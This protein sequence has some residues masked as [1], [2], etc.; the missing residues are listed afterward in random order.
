MPLPDY[1]D[2]S[3]QKLQTILKTLIEDENQIIL[4]IATGFFRIEAWVRL[5]AAMNQLTSLRLLIGRDPTIRPAESDR[6]DLIRYFRR[7]IQQQLEEEEFKSEYKQQ[8]DRMIAYLEQDHIQV[9]LYGATNGEFLHAKAYIF[10]HY[11][12][13]GSSNF[14]PAGI[15]TNR[16]LN[17]LNKHKAIAQDLRHNW[18]AE[19]WNH[20]SVDL[21]Y[22]TKLIDALNA[23]KFGSKAYTPYQVFL[24][25]LYE[26]FKDDSIIGESDRTT[27]ELASFQQEGFE[28]AVKLI[29]RHRGCMVADAVGLGKTFIGLRLLEYYLIK[30]RRPSKVPRALVICPAQ[31]RDLVWEKKLEEFGI[32][33]R[34]LSHEEISRQAFNIHDYARYDI[35]VVDESHNFRNSATNRYRNLLKLVSSGKRN[36]RVVLLTATPINNSIFDLYHQI[37]L[38]TR[39]GETYYR[40]WGIS[41]LKTYFKSL[42]KGG[43]EITELLLQTM[44]RRSRQDVIRRQQAGEEV[45][46]SGKVI[47]FPKRQ[48]EKFTYNFEDSFAGLYTGIA[49]QIDQLSLPAYN[50]KAFKKRKQKQDEDEVKRNDALVALQKA[51]YFKRFESSLIAFKSSI[52]SQRNF[53]TNFYRLLT[54]Q[55]KLLDSKNFRKLILASEDEEE[56]NSVNT[57]I[58]SLEEIESKD[59]D[60]NQLQQQIE[61]DLT[62]L[63]NIITKLQIIESSAA[64]NTDYDCKLAAFKNLLTTQLPGQRLLVFSYFKD[65]AN[66]LYQQLITDT[67]WLTQMQVNGKTPVI[68]LLTGATPGKQREEKVKRFAPKANAQSD[69]ELAALLQ[70]P[71][72]ILICTDVLSEGQNLQD[73]GV[74]VNYDLHWNPVRMIQRAG[75]IDRLG[76]DYDELFI[77]N[78]FPEQGLEDLLGLVRRLQ[79]RIATIDREVGLDGSVL[80]ETISDKSLEE[81]Y[82]LKM[83]DTDAEKE[84]ILA[85]LEQASDLVSLDEMRLPLLE[86]LQQAS[87]ELIDEIPFGIHST[88]NKLIAHHKVPNGGIFLAFKVKD[89]HFWH[90]YPRINGAISLDPT[91][92]IED[93]RTI[94]NWLK[95][96]QSDFPP[97][98]KLPPVEFDRRIFPVLEGAI[99]NIMTFFEQQQTAKGIKPQMSKLLQSIHHA[100]TQPDL[101]QSELIDEEAKERVLKVITT[102]NYRSYERDV[103]TIWESFKIHKNISLL[104]TELDE[105]FV[106]SDQYEELADDQN[107]RPVDII[108]KKDIK[109]ICYE[110]FKPDTSEGK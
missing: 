16:E 99:R 103:K 21:D 7:D 61:S 68:E 17:V 97:P 47:H 89:K 27:L 31:L 73:A 59:Y 88:S 102:V 64:A 35:V 87:K 29:E 52:T 18:F 104:V 66:Y 37:L 83:A 48:L 85:E 1:I 36:K 34:V 22:K 20:D 2:N 98:E 94:F 51:L 49:N 54:E 14:T 109:L 110:W 50:I 69:E 72:D 80:G 56:G 9:R 11:S 93:K 5:E 43:V 77:Y 86:F 105:Y 82:K 106:D 92:L 30:D 79:H 71:I 28:R 67:A 13:V 63:N 6:I 65:T 15:D 26:F 62:I 108:Q 46:I 41:N 78:C 24:K 91:S 4:D 53:Q 58:D 45:R 39:G 76:T 25:V 84:A 60:L 44:V 100:L 38:L 12:I 96:Q 90:F 33:A 32:K 40:E 3:R 19:F 75:R 81:L 10:D 57:I 8:I 101:F 42:A 55:G 74:L 23:S 95:C 107:I 70:N